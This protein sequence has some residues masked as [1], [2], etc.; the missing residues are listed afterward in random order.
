MAKNF[1][2]TKRVYKYLSKHPGASLDEIADAL[3]ISSRSNVRYH[4]LKL[5]QAG[6]VDMEY[7]QH[8]TYHVIEQEAK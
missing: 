1:E 6:K 8:R 4:M 7:Y 5:A 2:T 3:H